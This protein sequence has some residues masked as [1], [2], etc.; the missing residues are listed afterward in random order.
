MDAT[1]SRSGEIFWTSF[2]TISTR[3][4]AELTC[5]NFC[6]AVL[7]FAEKFRFISSLSLKNHTSVDDNWLYTLSDFL[8]LQELDIS[9]CIRITDKGLLT[10]AE[11]CGGLR[12][13]DC[14]HCSQVSDEGI[15]ALSRRCTMLESISI[16]GCPRVTGTALSIL[17]KCCPLIANVEVPGLRAA[18]SSEIFVGVLRRLRS[19]NVC[20]CKGFDDKALQHLVGLDSLESLAMHA[21]VGVTDVGLEAIASCVHLT[22]LDLSR[23]VMVT[24]FGIMKIAR[25]CRQMR[26]LQLDFC[27]QVSDMGISFIADFNPKLEHLSLRGCTLVTDVSVRG[28]LKHC[29][30]IAGMDLSNT[31]ANENE[32]R[33]C[34]AT[35]QEERRNAQE[36]EDTS[37][38]VGKRGTTTWTGIEVEATWPTTQPIDCEF[39]TKE[40]GFKACDATKFNPS[41]DL[42][43]TLA[44]PYMIAQ[45]DREKKLNI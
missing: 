13:L 38:L 3:L 5:K 4:S 33:A 43:H 35:L 14:S 26:R 17:F 25:G 1:S 28:V 16:R 39:S 42:H 22:T 36:E 27:T 37:W 40:G 20:N 24:N 19:L 44:V 21:N 41:R 30:C 7:T 29:P 34:I 6:R 23:C 8:H 11:G 15:L 12:K 10:L 31:S 2:H 9:H 45:Q 18:V 32:I